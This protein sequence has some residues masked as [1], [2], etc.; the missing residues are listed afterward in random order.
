MEKKSSDQRRNKPVK[1]VLDKQN[2]MPLYLQLRDLIKSH[3]ISGNLKDNEHLPGV[4]VLA[5]ELGINF[6]TVRKAYKELE[7]EGLIS[8]KKGRGTFV[9]TA[10]KQ[11]EEPYQGI[12]QEER[13][14][15]ATKAFI[16]KI[17]SE[18]KDRGA[19]KKMIDKAFDEVINEIHKRYFIYTEHDSPALAKIAQGLAEYLRIKVEP[20]PLQQLQ[21]EILADSRGQNLLTGIITTGISANDVRAMLLN[22]AIELHVVVTNMSPETRKIIEALNSSARVGFVCRDKEDLLLFRDQV[23]AEL[24]QKLRFRGNSL[25]DESRVKKLLKSV[26]VVLV[27][28]RAYADVKKMAPPRLP[29]ID[30]FDHIDPMSI[31]IIKEKIL[32]FL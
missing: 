30:I 31:K 23:K 8:I 3:I 25:K 20:V 2:K 13:T 7:K 27:T 10:G 5:A 15:E 24:M 22:S 26:D 29:V 16:K 11:G 19:A 4:N 21:R 28:P 18:V 32:Q 1:L 12:S 17:V 6:E 14:L 9:T